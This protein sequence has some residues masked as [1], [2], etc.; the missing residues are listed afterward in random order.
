[1]PVTY[2][3]RIYEID[4]YKGK[5]TTTYW[6]Q[7]KV[8]G[9]LPLKKRP[10][11]Q[12]ALA[13]SFRA[14]LISA[15]RKGEAFDVATGKP[16]SMSRETQDMSCF[17]LACKYVDLKWPRAAA[18]TRKTTAEALTAVLPLLFTRTT[19]KPDDRLIRT[20]LRRWAFN[21]PARSDDGKP[22]EIRSTLAW[23]ER[24]ARPASDLSDPKVLRAVLD[25]LTLKLDGTPGSPVVVTRRRK[26]FTGML[27]YGTEIKALSENPW[28]DFKWTPPRSANGGIDRRR[29]ANPMQIR[30]LFAAVAQQGRI[31]PRMVAYYGCLYFAA[32]RPE[33]AAGI[34]VPRNLILPDSDDEWC[35]FILETAEPHAGKHWTDS[36]NNRDRRQLKQRAIGETREV[37]GPPELTALI[38]HHI[39]TFK[40]G[41]GGRLFV[42][43]RNKNELPILTINR[44]WRQAR[45]AA[46]TP[47]VA[48]SPLAETPYDL[49]HAAVST[50]L[51]AGISPTQVAEWAGQSPEVLWR[52]YAK[53]LDGGQAELRRRVEAGYGARSSG[54]GL[55]YVLGTDHR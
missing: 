54:P 19:G 26:I 10:F 16:I 18:K 52:N 38:R 12:K 7:W 47:E 11:K 36:G 6:V 25:G 44:I 34:I 28:P 50:W 15:A 43:E 29:V 2:D 48:A 51:N 49:R 39:Q 55:R 27:E 17:E 33:E 9:K 22:H 40:L 42:G 5:T 21:T 53:C 30:T 14:D 20:A 37:A 35:T 8:A 1:M 45:K 31:G 3:V 46:F 4:V 24:N 23:I 32:M 13:V 41:P